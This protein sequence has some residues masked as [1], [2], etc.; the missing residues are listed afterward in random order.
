[1][2]VRLGCIG[3][4]NMGGAILRGMAGKE[5]VTLGATDVDQ[6][7]LDTLARECGVLAASSPRD[8]AK[9]SDYLL[10]AVK[11]HQIKTV[12]QDLA[13]HLT[14]EQTVVSVAAGVM[15]RDLKS[16][17]SGACPV[18]RVMP[19]T[20]AMVGRGLFAVC[21]D[22]PELTEA[23][24]S[25]VLDLFTPLGRVYVLEESAFD[26]F[27]AVAGSGPAYV[28]YFMEAVVEAGVTLGMPRPM[29]E[30]VVRELFAGSSRLVEESGKPLNALREMVTS[31]AGATI[32]AL[33]HLDRKAVRA[34]VIDAVKAS[35][36]RSKELGK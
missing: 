17:A 10:L 8:L 9:N 4:G 21:L 15:L 34:A 11:P 14:S 5:G 27:T 19:N 18:V 32:A 24:K 30:E 25:F 13:P 23:R 29:A 16:F 1:M 28:F 33:N 20:P 35:C 36:D 22:D 2:S 6:A 31:P 7:K 12:L 3:C 26:A